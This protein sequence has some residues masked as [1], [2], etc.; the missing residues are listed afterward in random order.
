MVEQVTQR[1]GSPSS[2]AIF[3]DLQGTSCVLLN[4]VLVIVLPQ[5]ACWTK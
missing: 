2:L 5:L 1:D 3:Q 4:L